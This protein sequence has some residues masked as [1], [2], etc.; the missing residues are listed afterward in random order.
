MSQDPKNEN[1]WQEFHDL[2]EQS[3]A[4]LMEDIHGALTENP[5]QTASVLRSWMKSDKPTERPKPQ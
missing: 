2:R 5:K 4:R 1:F 3:E